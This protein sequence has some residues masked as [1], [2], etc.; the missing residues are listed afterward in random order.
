MKTKDSEQNN[1]LKKRAEMY[2]AIRD[3]AKRQKINERAV[4]DWG[5]YIYAQKVLNRYK[6]GDECDDEQAEKLVKKMMLKN[7]RSSKIEKYIQG[8][9]I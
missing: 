7:L 9:N 6:E 2:A 3:F 8:E 5:W 4:R 1:W